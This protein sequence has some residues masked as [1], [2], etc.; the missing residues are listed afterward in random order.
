MRKT[1]RA[2]RGRV[3]LCGLGL[4]VQG[5]VGAT[6]KP[7]GGRGPGGADQWRRGSK[8]RNQVWSKLDA[9]MINLAGITGRPQC[10]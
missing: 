1:N 7:Y 9:K 5:W 8:G 2:N 10:V 3:R 4:I 6:Q